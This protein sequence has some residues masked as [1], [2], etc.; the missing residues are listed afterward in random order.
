[1]ILK[2]DAEE[3]KELKSKAEQWDNLYDELLKFYCDENG[4]YSEDNPTNEG[5]LG[6][7]GEAAASAFGF[8]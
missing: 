8:L 5:D 6:D 2:I 7:I 1:M 4:N 3:L